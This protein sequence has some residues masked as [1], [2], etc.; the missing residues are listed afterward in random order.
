MKNR[1]VISF[2]DVL[3]G[4]S[5]FIDM[6]LWRW[7]FYNRKSF[8]SA[9]A[10]PSSFWNGI[11]NNEI[12]QSNPDVFTVSAFRDAHLES[13]VEQLTWSNCRSE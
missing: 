2:Y 6:E 4:S 8:K 1:L 10:N 9:D 3:Q 13:P 5:A 11:D 12:V 7:Y